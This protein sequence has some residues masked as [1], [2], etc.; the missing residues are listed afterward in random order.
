MNA[1]EILYP[2][3][4]STLGQIALELATLL[5]RDREAKLLIVHVEEPTAY[6]G[7]LNHG[8]DEPDRKEPQRM[9]AAVIPTDRQ[10]GYGAGEDGHIEKGQAMRS[11]DE[12]RCY[13]EHLIAE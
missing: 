11:F 3:D 6:G 13:V 12:C 1:H 8:I 4:F 9:L 2:T 10:S 5:S 7:E